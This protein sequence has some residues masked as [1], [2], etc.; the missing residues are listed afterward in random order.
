MTFDLSSLTALLP[1]VVASLS[2]MVTNL[3]ERVVAAVGAKLPDPLKP[4]INAVAGAVLAGLA[5]G[6][7]VVGLVGA[8]V[9]NRV[10]EALK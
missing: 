10:R 2:P 8:Q 1:L 7:P 3:T 6:T 4:V 9:G 5:G